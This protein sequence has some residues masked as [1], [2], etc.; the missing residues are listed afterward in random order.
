MTAVLT[1]LH[2][3]KILPQLW[4]TAKENRQPKQTQLSS[5]DLQSPYQ[6]SSPS[7][8]FRSGQKPDRTICKCLKTF[9]RRTLQTLVF[10]SR[11]TNVN[12]TYFQPPAVSAR[13]SLSQAN[14]RECRGHRCAVSPAAVAELALCLLSRGASFFGAA[15]RQLGSRRRVTESAVPPR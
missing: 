2:I 15:R 9:D 5:R 11:K 12:D 3:S 13:Q 14:A 4:L 6:I 10:A 7:L 8:V 1:A